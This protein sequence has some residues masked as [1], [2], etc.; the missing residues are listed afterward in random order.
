MESKTK[1]FKSSLLPPALWVAILWVIY[2]AQVTFE[3]SPAY[4]GVHPR[5][6]DGLHGMFTSPLVHGS[7]S[8]LFNNSIPLFVSGASILY[9][10]PKVASRSFLWIFVVTGVATWLFARPVYHIGASGIVYGFIAFIF[11]SGV[12]RQNNR[13]IVLA[14]V[15]IIMY[16]G[17]L[18]GLVPDPE[19]RI[20]WDGHLVG[21]I[22]GAVI[23]YVYKDELEPDEIESQQNPYAYVNEEPTHYFLPRDIFEKTKLQR[24]LEAEEAMRQ[25]WESDNTLGD[26]D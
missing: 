3:F 17:M 21:L 9:F 15:V 13:S 8:H 14:L 1:R 22:V 5:H 18:A 10:F 2:F 16:S 25:R 6:L 20:S 19:N 11:W 12:F 4:L 26:L 24:R 7:L 23:A